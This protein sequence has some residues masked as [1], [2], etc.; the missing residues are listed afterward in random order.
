M[1]HS[2]LAL[3]P[4]WRE[5]KV[6][7]DM[8]EKAPSRWRRQLDS[9]SDSSRRSPKEKVCMRQPSARSGR[10]MPCWSEFTWRPIPDGGGCPS[11]PVSDGPRTSD[12]AMTLC[13]F[14]V[15]FMLISPDVND[16]E[17]S[18]PSLIIPPPPL[19]RT[20]AEAAHTLQQCPLPDA[21]QQR[22]FARPSS[23]TSPRSSRFASTPSDALDWPAEIIS[24]DDI[25]A[26][27][28]PGPQGWQGLDPFAACALPDV[29]AG[30]ALSSV[31]GSPTWDF[32]TWDPATSATSTGADA[33]FPD[34][35]I[36]AGH[37]FTRPGARLR[38]ESPPHTKPESTNRAPRSVVSPPDREV[39]EGGEA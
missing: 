12:R 32:L 13:R 25:A 34:L 27:G 33:T 31:D 14:P 22:R 23:S 6:P 38:V 28:L 29:N 11:F 1:E 19:I 3:F 30:A 21:Q 7:D 8:F 16:L 20:I 4:D 9:A 17:T 26:L 5:V 24:L 35:E 36:G 39:S 10:Q 2:P 15:P 37:P 18:P